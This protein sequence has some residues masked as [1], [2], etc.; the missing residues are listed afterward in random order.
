MNS[1]PT[2]AKGLSCE[3]GTEPGRHTGRIVDISGTHNFRDLGGLRT[4][5]G[6]IRPGRLFRSDSLQRLDSNGRSQLLSL[7]V[8][9]VVDLRMPNEE[10]VQPNALQGLAINTHRIPFGI[11]GG[12]PIVNDSFSLRQLY[13]RLLDGGGAVIRS[14]AVIVAEGGDGPQVVHCAAGKDRTGITLAVILSS[15]GVVR[16]DV[17]A[18]FALSERCLEG[19]WEEHFRNQLRSRGADPNCAIR[20]G[21]M[22]SPPGLM[23]WL[24]ASLD[25]EFG[26][27]GA[28][29]RH[30]GMGE[31]QLDRLI[32][33]LTET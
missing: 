13:R 27:A 7:G 30:H 1:H 4:A 18:D 24:L 14:V 31:R 2:A 29:L 9:E 3:L 10:L 12:S 23:R 8:R 20:N 26:G 16:D 5:R 15:V 28:F 21:A 32:E 6:R 33:V 19:E 17:C 11:D 22:A 25:D